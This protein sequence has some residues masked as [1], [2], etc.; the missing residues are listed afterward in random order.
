MSE[1]TEPADWSDV[2]DAAC[3]FRDTANELLETARNKVLR[4]TILSLPPEYDALYAVAMRLWATS[5]L[6]VDQFESKA[7]AAEDEKSRLKNQFVIT[8][9]RAIG[10]EGSNWILCSMVHPEPFDPETSKES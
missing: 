3:E 2:A 9:I 4:G 7:G 8:P 10:P 1:L 5:I 6:A